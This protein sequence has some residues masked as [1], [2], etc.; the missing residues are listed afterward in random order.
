MP[1][2]TTWITLRGSANIR[3]Q[4]VVYI[5]AGYIV[6]SDGFS[7]VLED[8]VVGIG[9]EVLGRYSG[10]PRSHISNL[11]GLFFP[12]LQRLA[13]VLWFSEGEW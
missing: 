5:V 6:A 12:L 10:E 7:H 1:E 3:R 11:W 13:C 2:P 8:L 9:G 4:Q